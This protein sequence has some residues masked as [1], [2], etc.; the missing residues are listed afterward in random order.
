MISED[1]SHQPVL[2]I[3]CIE[4][5]KI[6]HDGCY[7][8]GTV[9]GGGHS[10]AIL[11]RLSEKGRLICL[12]KDPD[13]IAAASKRL[14]VYPNLTVIEGD[15]RDVKSLI[16]TDVSPFDG[17]LLDLGVSSHQL[18]AAGRGFSYQRDGALDMRMSQSGI[19][20][21]D[22]VNTYEK[23]KLTAILRDYGEE[24][25]AAFIAKKIVEQRQIKPISTTLEFSETVI[26]SL[27]ASV[28][29]KEK[30][31]ARKSFMALRIATNDELNA[32]EEGM[33]DIFDLMAPGGRFCIITFHSIEDRIVKRFFN[34]LQI[35]CTCP[36]SFPVCVCDKKPKARGITKK[37]VVATENE[38]ET[39]RRARSAKLRIIE[40]R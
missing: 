19:S 40:K 15:F 39:N 28:R 5:L 33:Q 9:G 25:Y 34:E 37:P 11:E 24:R 29:R 7:L 6:N 31:P 35:G 22:I 3:K 32:L 36:P 21:A 12:D 4:G 20:A 1:F 2:L 18:D 27:P 8:D 26:S 30:N 16:R 13:A 10:E 17:V 38:I 14:S 23:E